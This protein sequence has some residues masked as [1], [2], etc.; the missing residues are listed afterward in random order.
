MFGRMFTIP[1]HLR[2][3]L[4]TGRCSSGL[5]AELD[6]LL[7]NRITNIFMITDEIAAMEGAPST[8]VSR[9][10]PGAEFRGKWLKGL[11]HK[12]HLH[13]SLNAMAQNIANQWKKNP[14]DFLVPEDL[15][16]EELWQIAGK[17]GHR[18]VLEGYT[19]RSDAGELTGEWIV[20]AKQDGANYY[21]TLGS[22]TE[23]D[24]A[25]WQRCKLCAK[26]FPEL[27][28]LKEKRPL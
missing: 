2:T 19:N 10:K 27:Q 13:S 12:H 20:L 16:N 18:V 28:V 23:T 4:T 15:S 6:H 8:R 9:T 3:R 22:H 11:W 5:V 26:Q 1:E 25:V 14:E 24:E 7:V 21:L 17:I